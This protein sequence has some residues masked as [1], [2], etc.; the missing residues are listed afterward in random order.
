MDSVLILVRL[1]PKLLVMIIAAEVFSF[2]PAA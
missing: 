1:T 2:S